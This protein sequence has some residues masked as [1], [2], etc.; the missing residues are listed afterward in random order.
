M[1]DALERPELTLPP[2]AAELLRMEYDRATVIL[3]Y[4]SGGST[5][6]A[7]EMTGKQVFT[8]ESDR[9]WINMMRAWLAAYPPLSQVE[10]HHADIG[11][12]KKWGHPKD[13]TYWRRFIGYPLSVWDRPDFIHPDVVLIDGRF[14][15]GCFLATLMRITRPV[16]VL[17]DDYT[18]RKPYA[19]VEEFFKPTGF[20]DRMARFEVE[21][22]IPTSSEFGRWAALMQKPL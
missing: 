11:P 7:A 4:G 19:V 16:T 22:R 8:V 6:L 20:A 15:V 3:E 10:I 17:F 2:E 21:P 12:T 13:E 18:G 9:G 5:L 1:T 14:R